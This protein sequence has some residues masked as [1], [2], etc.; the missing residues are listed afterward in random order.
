MEKTTITIRKT[1]HP[2]ILKF[3]A[4]RFLTD[5]ESFEFN[6]I[7][8][9]KSSSLAQQLFYLPFIKKVYISGNF[10]ALER[11]PIVE[12]EDVQE[13]VAQQIEQYINEGKEV[14]KA[15]P[16]AKVLPSSVYAEVT[17]NP[18]VM[19]F[20]ANRMLVPKPFEFT[21]P[22]T[23]KQAPLAQEL[24][25]LPFV[26]GV[27]FDENFVSITKNDVAQWDEI[28]VELR[29]F[30]KNYIDSGKAIVL[31]GA[32][33]SSPAMPSVE[34][35]PTIEDETSREIIAILNEYVKPAVARDGGNIVFQ[36]Y[37]PER[38]SVKVILQGAC[39]GCP[40]ST[41]TLKNGIEN[42]LKEMLPGK[43]A[44]VD[45]ING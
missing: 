19:K 15:N 45:A 37:D 6:N 12:W 21:S 23:A 44:H 43:V 38:K 14:V 29:E 27:Y 40:S 16:T 26:K 39:S 2:D 24:F 35:E 1:S 10:I 17:P 25:H 33:S 11:F 3:E 9:A 30:I 32:T 18:G 20:V 31:E 13:E 28:T 7:D 4:D 5:H 36:S 8:E 41:Y 42:I 34:A 22:E